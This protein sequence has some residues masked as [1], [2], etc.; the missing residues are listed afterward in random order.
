MLIIEESRPVSNVAWW[1]WG[2]SPNVSLFQHCDCGQS[3]RQHPLS[4]VHSQRSA[5]K[6]YLPDTVHLVDLHKFPHNTIVN[7][8]L[9]PHHSLQSKIHNG[10]A[11][12]GISI[13]GLPN[14]ITLMVFNSIDQTS[15]IVN[16]R[17]S[18][19]HFQAFTQPVLLK[20]V[21]LPLQ[22]DP[23]KKDFRILPDFHRA[24]GVDCNIPFLVRK[25]HLEY[26]LDGSSTP[27]K[28][29][30]L[31]TWTASRSIQNLVL[32]RFPRVPRSSQPT[33]DVAT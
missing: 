4:Q 6:I 11:E 19:R 22:P 7:P 25:L 20:D 27:E 10:V 17:K 26:D 9:D 30:T 1:L 5:P 29:S 18:H 13:L 12:S 33:R 3:L 23:K 21:H 15:D 24:A 32:C 28:L 31:K 8:Q 2:L 14:E 16:L